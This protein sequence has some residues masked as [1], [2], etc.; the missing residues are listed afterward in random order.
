MNLLVMYKLSPKFQIQSCTHNSVVG[1]VA[2][3]QV[4]TSEVDESSLVPH[5]ITAIHAS[6]GVTTS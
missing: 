6:T 4:I 3:G 5:R 2:R 1:S